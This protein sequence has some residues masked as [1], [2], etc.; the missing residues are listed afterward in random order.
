[1]IPS[2]VANILQSPKQDK[3]PMA[4]LTSD[5]VPNHIIIDSLPYNDIHRYLGVPP[6]FCVC[7]FRV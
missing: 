2:F 4:I 7:L 1:M 3:D 6:P 5:A